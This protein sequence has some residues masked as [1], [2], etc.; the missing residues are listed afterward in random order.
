[1][2]KSLSLSSWYHASVFGFSFFR[3]DNLPFNSM[4][5][6]GCQS[7]ALRQDEKKRGR[8]RLQKTEWT[9]LNKNGRRLLRR[10]NAPSTRKYVLLERSLKVA[11]P[12]SVFPLP[13][14]C[15]CCYR[16]SYPCS[17]VKI[18]M[19]MLM[20]SK[21]NVPIC[22]DQVQNHRMSSNRTVQSR[23]ESVYCISR[24]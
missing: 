4:A 2:L 9:R 20:L 10:T 24:T 15:H 22:C 12:G 19:L 1:M 3:L 14:C 17:F 6:I 18:L 11:S 23:T 7:H 16:L 8:P 21:T 13:C 5:T